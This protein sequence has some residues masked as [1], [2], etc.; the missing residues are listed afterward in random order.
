MRH[1]RSETLTTS[2]AA[3]MLGVSLTTTQ[4]MVDRG[5]IEAWTTEGGHRRISRESVLRVVQSSSRSSHSVHGFDRN[6]TIL[7]AEDD[8]VQVA[9][10]QAILSRFEH[11]HLL[12][13][14]PD[15][16]TA[17]VQLERIKPDVLIT[18]LM[19]KPFDGFYLL[20]LIQ[21]DPTY[22]H[23]DVV[24]CSSMSRS[25]AC[26]QGDLHSW[27]THYRK[28]VN[29]ERILG[30]LDSVITRINRRKSRTL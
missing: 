10:F 9:F 5:E 19:M 25:E 14:A 20:D 21:S 13:V 3:E 1:K 27:V 29:P 17:L 18:D 8:P 26:E 7:L 6:L 23:L 12:V 2:Q 11:A 28:P 15:A 30:F 16:S 24:V 4:K 22:L